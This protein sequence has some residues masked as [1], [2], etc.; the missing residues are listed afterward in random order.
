MF[1]VFDLDGTLADCSHRT[2]FICNPDGSPKPKEEKDWDG[3]YAACGGD[4][5]HKV[6]AKLAAELLF[7]G[8]DVQIWTGRSSIAFYET[9]K[10]LLKQGIC[11]NY[12]IES[13]GYKGPAIPLLRMRPHGDHT[14]DHLLKQKWMEE[15]GKPD[16]V[17]E[18]RQRVVDMWRANGVMCCQVAEGDF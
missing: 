6:L 16:L 13:H 3:F 2:H 11:S 7:L 18:D 4:A 5:P 9:E 14:P 10:W 12:F 15:Y 8:H 1:V 17:F